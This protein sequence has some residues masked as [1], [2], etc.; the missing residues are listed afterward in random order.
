M[1]NAPPDHLRGHPE[2][3]QLPPRDDAVLTTGHDCHLRLTL[4]PCEGLNVRRA[5]HNAD[6]DKEIRAGGAQNVPS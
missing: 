5:F 2:P 1:I 4:W 6:A 3:R